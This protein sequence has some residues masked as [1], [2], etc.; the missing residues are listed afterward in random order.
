MT[1]GARGMVH[2]Q[3]GAGVFQCIGVAAWESKYAYARHRQCWMAA[4]C[5]QHACCFLRLQCFRSGGHATLSCCRAICLLSLAA[6]PNRQQH[7]GKHGTLM[8]LQCHLINHRCPLALGRFAMLKALAVA[9]EA[10]TVQVGWACPLRWVQKQ[11]VRPANRVCPLSRV[12][13]SKGSCAPTSLIGSSLTHT[14]HHAGG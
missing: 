14:Q 9:S 12:N 10:E 6:W 4:M 8:L 1:V 7:E 3:G 2:V 5:A 13:A 11:S